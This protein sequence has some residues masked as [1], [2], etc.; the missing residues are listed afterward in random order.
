MKKYSKK[1]TLLLF[2]SIF[3]LSA[4]SGKNNDSYQLG[5]K[6]YKNGEYTEAV[7][8]FESAISTDKSNE[9]YYI[10]LG[11]TYIELGQYEKA[12]EQFSLALE[13]KPDNKEIHRGMGIAYLGIKDY[14]RALSSFASALSYANGKVGDLEFDILDYRGIAEVK[15]GMYTEAI[16]TYSILI[17][18]DY[19]TAYHYFLRGNV[20]L[21]LDD[22]ESAEND[23]EKAIELTPSD[24]KLYL[25]IYQ[26]LYENHPNV[27]K[28]YLE[29]ALLANP[30]KKDDS[31]NLGKIYYYLGD[32]DNSI[33]SLA[34]AKEKGNSE[35]ILFLGKI[36]SQV[37]NSTQAFLSFQE[38]VD[39][40][41][42]DGSVYNEM[43]LLKLNAGEYLD[44]LAYFQDGIECNDLSSLKELRFN[45]AIV[46]EFLGDFDTAF[47]KFS[48]YLDL[49]P[50][51]AVALREY[52]FL[53][54]R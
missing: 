31:L 38:Y 19:H 48:D 6:H 8:A 27:A 52:D 22:L 46:Y 2:S 37:G 10:N 3:L 54:T 9:N 47:S 36:Y 41:P 13:L 34:K 25:D 12:L 44:A 53:K 16:D 39:S 30:P 29:K 50:D 14:E 42:K 21:L 49:Y 28:K 11:M 17:T 51:D 1:L 7:S 33:T 20:Y 4:C 18:I 40:N 15:S 24:Y 35:A 23:F 43:G 32:Y 45:E 5:I 26:G